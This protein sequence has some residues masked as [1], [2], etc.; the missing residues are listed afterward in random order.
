MENLFDYPI[1][2]S[3]KLD[4]KVPM[5]NEKPQK[6]SISFRDVVPEIPSTTHGAFS[7][8]KYPAKFIPQVI[9]Y[10]LKKYG[11]PNMKVFDPFAGYGTVG[12]VCRIYG[13]A[14]ELWDLNPIMNIIHNTAILEKPEIDLSKLMTEIKMPHEEFIPKW[15]NLGYWFP[16]DFI[17]TLAKTW[18]F[19][20]SLED[21]NKYVL[22]LPIFLIK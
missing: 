18:G 20:H 21:K 19:V 17:P 12:V 4:R 6:I 22:L 8:Y 3:K 7:I 2:N 11:K 1:K 13:Y 14:Y 10:V 16:E 5:M 15:S 9:D